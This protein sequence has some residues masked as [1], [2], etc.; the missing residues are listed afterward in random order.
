MSRHRTLSTFAA[1]PGTTI[2]AVAAALATGRLIGI[3]EDRLRR[4]GP[5]GQG[6]LEGYGMANYEIGAEDG[7]VVGYRARSAESFDRRRLTRDS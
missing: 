5:Y 2:A 1:A 6:Y 3:A 4:R 7:F